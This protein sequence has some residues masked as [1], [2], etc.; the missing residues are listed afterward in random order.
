MKDIGEVKQIFGIQIYCDKVT[1]KLYL[2]WIYECFEE[3]QYVRRKASQWT[4]G[5]LVTY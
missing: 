4:V 1:E 3:V 2:G 5:L